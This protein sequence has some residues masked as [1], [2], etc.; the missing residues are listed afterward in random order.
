MLGSRHATGMGF[1]CREATEGV[2]GKFAN[3]LLRYLKGEA[4]IEAP[5]ER[6]MS[7]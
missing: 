2:R 5:S 1:S 7:A 4:M 3:A 6:K